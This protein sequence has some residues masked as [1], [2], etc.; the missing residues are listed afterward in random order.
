M[1][2]ACFGPVSGWGQTPSTPSPVSAV[3]SAPT[4][5]LSVSTDEEIRILDAIDAQS[6]TPE[7]QQATSV[8]SDPGTQTAG[9]PVSYAPPTAPTGL[10]VL[11][12]KEGVYLSW[13]AP[14][15]GSSV[16]AYTVY[17]STTPGEGYK[18]VNAKP[19]AA[20]YFLDGLQTSLSPPRNGED[21]FYVV[22][23]TNSSGQTSPTSDEITVTPQGMEIPEEA[24][25]GGGSKPTPTAT[26]E[27]REI[28]IPEKNIVNLQLPADTQ[29]S[30]QGYKK[31]DVEMAFQ[32][33]Y[34]RPVANGIL[35]EQDTTLVNQ[36]LVVNLQGK[37]GKNVDVNVDY[38]DVNRAGGVDQSKQVISIV[39]HGD[40]DSPVQEVEFGD[41]QLLLPN[42]EFAGFSKNLFG[43]QAK[44][45]FDNFRLTSFFAQTKGIAETKTFTGNS[46]QVDN[47]IQDITYVPNKY[48]L[49]TRTV[50][51]NPYTDP[52]TGLPVNGALPQSNSE[53][54]WV[55]AGTGQ[56]NPSGPNF[57]GPNNAFE[58]WLPGRDYTIDYSTGII[59]FI[60]ALPSTARIAVGYFP[61]DPSLPMVG[62]V[63]GTNP[64]NASMN[65][66]DN[67]GLWVPDLGDLGDPNKK[68]NPGGSHVLS[69]YLIKDNNNST[70]NSSPTAIACSPLYLMN[71]YNLGTNKIVP[72]AQDPDFLFQ[73]ISNSNTVLQTG[74]GVSQAGA[75]N[76][77]VYNVDL[78]YNYLTVTNSNF[79]ASGAPASFL[80]PERPFANLDTTG[81][82]S[83][84]ASPPDVYCQ[85]VAPFSQYSIH[86]RY[87]TE[88]NSYSLGRFNIIQGSESVFLDGRRLR[89]DVDYLFDYTSGILDFPD[90]SILRPDSQVVVSYEYA[91]FGSFSQDNILG[92]RAEYDISDNFFIGSTFLEEDAQQPIDVPQIGSTPNS[93]TLFDADSRL[94]LSQEDVRSLTSAIPGL[95]NWKPPLSVKLSGEV[96]QS[97]YNPDTFNVEGETGV[98]MLDNMEGIDS[99]TGASMNQTSWL[100]SAAPE[101]VAF[102]GNAEYDAGPDPANN[103]TRFY[104]PS[105]PNST[106]E[107]FQTIGT[108][109]T[110]PANFTI[111]PAYGGH[112]YAQTQQA[113]DAVQ[114]L[115]FP[116]ANLTNNLWAGLRQVI[117]VNGTDFSNVTYV[118]TWVYND[119][120]PKWIMVDFGVMSEE[121]NGVASATPGSNFFSDPNE[122]AQPQLPANP[123]Y[124]IPTYYFQGNPWS[125]GG[126]YAAPV[127]G[128]F[129]NEQTS[130]EGVS[131]GSGTGYVSEDLNGDNILEGSSNDAYYEYGVQANWTGWHE[132]K[133]PVN[134]TAPDGMSTTPDGLTYFFHTQGLASPTIIRTVRV[135]MTGT[136]PT[137]YSG[138]VYFEN[139]SFA[140][141]LWQ[142]Q[143]DPTAP[144]GV[145]VNTSEFDANSISQDQNPSYQPTLRFLTVEA[146][147]DES[148][149]L[150]K[151]KSLELTYSLLKGDPYNGMLYATR[152]FN[153]GLDFTDYLDMRID[154]YLRSYQPGDTLYVRVG[155]DPQDYYQYSVDLAQAA[156]TCLNTWGTVIIPLDGSGGN[157]SQ[158]GT[159]YINRVTNISFGIVS[160]NQVL[161]FVGDLW[162][163]NLRC[164]N[165]NVRSGMARRANAAFLI[166]DPK[167]PF[168]TINTRYREVDSGFTE[169]DQTSTHFQHSTQ[170]GADYTSSGVSLFSQPLVTQASYTHQDLTT[171]SALMNN[172]YYIALPDTHSDN[173][174]G[175]ISYTKDLGAA[176]GRL[177]AV[178]LSGSYDYE[179]DNYQTDYL[180]QPGV[181][182]NTLKDQEVYT[183]AS[184]YDAPQKLLFLP[185]GA[186]QLTETYSITH[187]YQGFLPPNDLDLASYDRTTRLQT[188]GW[189]NTTE[190]VKNLVFTP[191]YNWTLTDAVGNTTSPGV[192]VSVSSYS[193]TFTPFQEQQQPK[194]GLVYRGI[195]GLIPSVA[196]TG[197]NSYDWVSYSDG[198]RFSNAN[199]LNFTGNFTPSSWFSFL[200]KI[201]PTVTYGRTYASTSAIP[202][203]HSGLTDFDE[204]WGIHPDFTD[205][206]LATQSQTDQLSGD[207]KLFD[208]WDFRPNASWNNQLSLL[209]QGTYPVKQVGETLGLT[210][211]YNRKLFTL[212]LVAFTM[213]S[214]Q[215]QYTHT[216]ST[217]YDSSLPPEQVTSANIANETTSDLYG[218]TIPY[219]LGKNFAQGNVH[220]QRTIGTQDGLSTLNTLVTQ[221]D[222]QATIEYDQKFA[223][224]LEIHIP[225]THWKLKLENAIE[226]K[227]TFLMEF[228]NNQ[229]TYINN[230]TLTQRYRGT[231]ALNY[232]ALKNLRIGIGLTNEYFTNTL[233]PQLDYVLWQGDIS[234]E[235]RF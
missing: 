11:I 64:T 224:N 147:Q 208:V 71:Y 201:N 189:T 43:L 66:N 168:A 165:S 96:A 210:T 78:D 105:A 209:S 132:V 231:I 104:N 21:Y 126:S 216:D 194:A 52:T 63:S 65:L 154:L 33:F 226:L 149:I 6:N 45:K 217:Q 37:V 80:W 62:Y 98:A 234:A 89:R 53:Q 183:L 74:Q 31:I 30:I 170:L 153:Q 232:N 175:S 213:D 182:G 167:T 159:P 195:P 60:R 225:F 51:P 106:M 152:L 191:G 36:E 161:G 42:T 140:H 17:R 205:S 10:S 114:V 107:V 221:L 127:S 44:M 8:T 187:D 101:P 173:A 125:Q 169:I 177:T 162:I 129:Q 179:T 27:E 227:A 77:W 124:G 207:F 73:V 130:Q 28:A 133:I 25:S 9:A 193:A 81:G 18:R 123:N 172:P 70:G 108:Q 223:P 112:I 47:I 15:A 198:L 158:V 116:Y 228:I 148:A 87:K 103:R 143:V 186:N 38:S 95:E 222:D 39:Y 85:T 137:P 128:L 59:T 235:A 163:N 40:Q 97:Y 93:L 230:E 79:L 72:P 57:A 145:T 141:N 164:T 180:S 171:E 176:W 49:I 76:P 46:V 192:P 200:Q 229:S 58:H 90:K 24:L 156:V 26:P 3:S 190:I 75:S 111:V 181:Q 29:L 160:Q 119:G 41:L 220:L 118:D 115:Q 5:D 7:A 61:K 212:P 142:L 120:N 117:S 100:V 83:S 135:W 113:N 67:R 218:I 136:S 211:V 144:A 204:Q 199:N 178:R 122:Y 50:D 1:A 14:P 185:I 219:E 196:Y 110:G 86:I 84:S 92:A 54:I 16:T 82:S 22:S 188:Y 32:D 48:Y 166:G 68:L 56:L 88:S 2:F 13:D 206:L 233:N 138:D 131:V 69:G 19:V 102:L 139:I 109:N 4:T 12:L 34:N 20:P 99:V 174:T 94:D 202:G 35:Q 151:E 121:S 197:S 134:F 91:P 184:T 215:F 150:Y 23:A 203:Y 146:G 214:A 155:N 157:R 55:D